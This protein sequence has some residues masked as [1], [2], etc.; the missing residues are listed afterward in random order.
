[1]S[2]DSSLEQRQTEGRPLPLA[3]D[4]WEVLAGTNCAGEP[5]TLS[6]GP[7]G[8]IG[9]DVATACC[10]IGSLIHLSGTPEGGRTW[11][12]DSHDPHPG[13]HPNWVVPSLTLIDG[14]PVPEDLAPAAAPPL[15]PDVGLYGDEGRYVTIEGRRVFI[16]DRSGHVPP[17]LQAD[18]GAG[19]RFSRAALQ[20][21]LIEHHRN[22][23]GESDG[24]TQA[25]EDELTGAAGSASD[26]FKFHRKLPTEV[27]SAIADNPVLR[28]VFT[29]TDDPRKAHGPDAFAELSD[30][31]FSIAEAKSG[32]PIR[33][34]LQRRTRAKTPK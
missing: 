27:K 22:I 3:A 14:P 9:R 33:A 23:T 11:R 16:L 1:M 30:R 6:V 32:S 21:A 29:V 34:A 26:A 15:A 31:Y 28:R 12:V 24:Y 18:A 8:A 25:M 17:R 7:G 4:S 13:G 10:P 5:V 2:Y 20:R 19:K